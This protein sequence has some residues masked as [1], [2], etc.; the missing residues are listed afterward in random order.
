MAVGLLWVVRF[1]VYPDLFVITV[2]RDV[3]ELRRL[4][5]AIRIFGEAV[6]NPAFTFLEPFIDDFSCVVH[7]PS[8]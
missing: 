3:Q 5:A 1:A 2:K 6:A 4:L 8:F 7:A